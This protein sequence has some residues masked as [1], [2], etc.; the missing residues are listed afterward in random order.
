MALLGRLLQAAEAGGRTGSVVEILVLQ[1][2]AHELAG[3]VPAALVPLERALTLAE[4]E[5]YVRIFI[6]EGPPMASLLEA[7]AKRRIVPDYARRLLAAFG[8]DASRPP[9]E[10]PVIEPLSEREVE[11]L[12]LLATDLDG[13][14][15][16]RELVVSLNTLRTHT[17]NIY[18]KL[19]V[20]TRMAAVRRAEELGLLPRA[21]RP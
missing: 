21:R 13:P 19:G 11:V 18:S 14:E 5:G 15:I 17:K 8:A 10:Q 4:P 20:S 12:A 9:V 2:L 1:A 16:A 3:D 6:D 7:A